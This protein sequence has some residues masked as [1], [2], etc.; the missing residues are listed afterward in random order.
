MHLLIYLY[1]RVLFAK[2]EKGRQRE[3]S[4][5]TKCCV[6]I[7]V[8]IINASLII[9]LYTQNYYFP[10][11][12]S[13]FLLS[14]YC[15]CNDD[16]TLNIG[17]HWDFNQENQRPFCTILLRY[18]LGKI[19]DKEGI[20]YY[21]CIFKWQILQLLSILYAF[22]TDT[23]LFASSEANYNTS[24]L[25]IGARRRVNLC[26][27]AQGPQYINE[28]FIATSEYKR[29][30]FTIAFGVLINNNITFIAMSLLCNVYYC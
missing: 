13:P 27:F 10:I 5:F 15:F 25:H 28:R 19:K 7:S 4:N 22:Y 1:N 3:K 20:D 8:Q 11:E 23:G 14:R 16:F 26:I 21:T 29:W 30:P 9:S 24:V 18:L 12:F 17:T 6:Y 2:R